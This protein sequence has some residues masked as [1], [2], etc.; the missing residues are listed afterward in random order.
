MLRSPVFGA[1]ACATLLSAT[2]AFA[3][4]TLVHE[5]QELL[6]PDPAFEYFGTEIAVDGDWA[7]IMAV[8]YPSESRNTYDQVALLYRR[9]TSGWSFVRELVRDRVDDSHPYV[10]AAVAMAG[11]YAAISLSP[12][13]MYRRSGSTWMEVSHPFTAPPNTANWVSGPLMQWS[14]S[15]LAAVAGAGTC[16]ADGGPFGFDWGVLVATRGSDGAWPTPQRLASGD[17]DCNREIP[18]SLDIDGNTLAVSSEASGPMLPAP[19]IRVYRRSSTNWQSA[20]TLPGR[21]GEIAVLG[22]DIFVATGS[23]DGTAVYR[24]DGSQTIVDN[25]RAAGALY[26]DS[27]RTHLIRKSRDS[28]HQIIDDKDRT[29]V[30]DTFRKNDAGRYEHAAILM[31]RGNGSLTEGLAASGRRV[32]AGGYFDFD[33]S[34]TAVYAFDLP[35]SFDPEAIRQHTFESGSATGWT[36]AAGSQFAVVASGGNRVYRQSSLAG[37]SRAVLESSEGTDQAIEA[38][39]RPTAF[40][41]NDRWAGLAVRY[42]DPSNYYYVTLRS[43]GSIQLRRIVDGV[44][45]TLA[46]QS[47]PIVAGRNYR[48]HLQALGENLRVYVD[49]RLLLWSEDDALPAGRVALV[50]YRTSADFDNVLVEDIGQN[51]IYDFQNDLCEQSRIDAHW[52]TNGGSWTCDGGPLLQT[53]V[54]GDARAVTGVSTDDQVVRARVRA[55]SFAAPSGSQER[56]VGISTRYRDTG[57]YYYLSL[58][59]SN[60]ISLRKLVNGSITVLRSAPLDVAAGNWYDLKLEAIGNQVRGYVNGALVLQAT[61]SSHSTG[62]SGTVT[63]KAAAEYDGFLAYQP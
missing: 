5:S 36:A 60:Q 34:N 43:S 1:L 18:R 59:S 10:G 50:G 2:A 49:G 42:V 38:D 54:A 44:F 56:W 33:S 35:E 28:I 3:R 7:I 4:P 48:V 20:F 55:T 46:L 13:R 16:F 47:V 27:G 17:V 40:S 24:N 14:G 23:R 41:G 31:P 8:S 62:R 25:L 11:G 19:P 21:N 58:R 6:P 53:S 37:D 32:L 30:V 22:D 26:L 39:I 12:L 9:T 29:L 63:F 15:T 51:S 52:T 45:S 57:N 61:D